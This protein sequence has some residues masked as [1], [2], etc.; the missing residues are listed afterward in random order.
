MNGKKILSSIL[1]CSILLSQS[2]VAFAADISTGTS[3][4]TLIKTSRVG[5]DGGDEGPSIV[6]VKVPSEIPISQDEDGVSTVADNL[7]VQN[8][9]QDTDIEVTGINVTGKN[10][11]RIIDYSDDISMETEGTKKLGLEFRGDGTTS[12]GDFDI[13]DGNWDVQA[14]SSIQLN[15]KAKLP[16]QGDEY[17]T[18]QSIATVTWRVA[19]SA[20][21]GSEDGG[22]EEQPPVEHEGAITNNWDSATKLLPTGS[23]GVK[24][25]WD[26]TDKGTTITEVKSSDP[27]VATITPSALNSL[28]EMPF[29][30]TADYTVT[31]LKKGTTTV[32]ATLSSGEQ[33]QFDVNVY[34][35]SNN[36]GSSGSNEIEITVPGDGFETGDDLSD[37][38]ITIEIPVTT[39]D[40]GDDVIEIKPE[41]PDGT[42]LQPGDNEIEVEVEVDG[43]VIKITIVIRVESSNPSNGLTQTV[44]DAQAMG[45]TFSSYEDGLQIDSFE[46]KQFKSEINVPEKIGDFKVLKIG[47]GVFKN[48]TNLTK[49]TLP[50]TV[51]SIMTGAFSGCEN[52]AVYALSPNLEASSL[53]TF[54]GVKELHVST[55]TPG[56][57]ISGVIEAIGNGIPVHVDGELFEDTSA[58]AYVRNNGFNSDEQWVLCIG[59]DGNYIDPTT[60]DFAFGG[61]IDEPSLSTS[62][63]DAVIPK[64][65]NGCLIT[66]LPEHIVYYQWEKNSQLKT[67]YIPDSVTK[68]RS[69]SSISPN[70]WVFYGYP[71]SGNIVVTVNNNR[72]A[73]SGIS[74]S[75]GAAYLY[76]DTPRTEDGVLVLDE[77]INEISD[78]MFSNRK[79]ITSVVIPNGVTSI[80]EFSFAGCSNLV[81]VVIPDGVTTIDQYAFSGCKSLTSVNIPN[82]VTEIGS[83]V[84]SSCESLKSI[85]IPG[86][87]SQIGDYAF[88]KCTSLESVDI[89][90]GVVTIEDHAFYGCTKIGSLLIP[91]SVTSIGEWAFNKVQ[92]I[93][94]H[95]SAGSS[96]ATWGAGSRN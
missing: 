28:A 32:T 18:K 76:N 78:Y 22:N 69:S 17:D 66:T 1:A 95:G 3:D 37:S 12:T 71:N 83:H 48:Q 6:Q 62:T 55:L 40:G 29:S 85:S 84:F 51:S 75:S 11:W 44:E 30:G 24:F 59:D 45:F 67:L 81:S 79:D 21:Q 33:T 4:V 10:G 63:V 86:C 16:L 43:V 94:Y 34:E 54:F 15:A 13:T 91:D 68:V 88:Y 31:A 19:I 65:V 2:A 57:N 58:L 60:L 39:P 73:I 23:K 7:A 41:I 50:N 90:D 74:N 89:Q 46:N 72:G 49:I 9:S 38:N 47:T 61:S 92:H 64:Y 53:T 36:T 82:G 93:E 56:N 35:L 77:G 96:T 70:G 8:L 20:D 87:V 52:A 27:E 42:E 5:E 80:G 26:S 25:S 14:D